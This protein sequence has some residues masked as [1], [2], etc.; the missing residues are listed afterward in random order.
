MLGPPPVPQ[1]SVPTAPS[2]ITGPP[3]VPAGSTPD[4]APAASGQPPPTGGEQERVTGDCDPS[5]P[6]ICLPLPPLD[7]DCGDIAFRFFTVRPPDPHHFDV[8]GNGVGCE[9]R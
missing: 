9:H 2:A 6:D 1:G 3:A 8:D 5:Y 7:L 4:Q